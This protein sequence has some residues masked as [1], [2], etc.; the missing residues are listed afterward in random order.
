MFVPI[1]NPQKIPIP[2]IQLLS[3]IFSKY[4]T[5]R[6]IEELFSM[7][8]EQKNIYESN[9]E[10]TVRK[11][12]NAINRQDNPRPFDVLGIL[13]EDFMNKEQTTEEEQEH[14][15]A[16]QEK[17]HD[18]L[19]KQGL[20]YSSSR[21]TN[22]APSTYALLELVKQHGL[23][24]VNNEI[25]RA[26]KNIETDPPSAALHAGSVLE[27]SL[28]AYFDICKISYNKE[29]DTLSA[30]WKRF[31]KHEKIQP[32]KMKNNDSKEIASGLYNIINGTMS[33]RNKKS[34][35]HG[36]SEE[37]LQEINNIRPRHARL[38]VHAAHTVSAYILE[39]I[40]PR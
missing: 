15:Q 12:L 16:D 5:R 28:K 9:K 29:T 17:L 7:A 6:Q 36:R 22:E 40:P 32:K 33:L 10:S 26:L 38:V 30:L 13:I 25:Q 21:L 11:W 23:R 34:S 39:F 24:T 35:A 4:Y 19:S 8:S 14:L 20:S 2:I 18:H 1:E 37:Q 31:T 27:A 3:K